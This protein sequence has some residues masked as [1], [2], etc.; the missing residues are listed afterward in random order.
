MNN[1]TAKERINRLEKYGYNPIHLF[2]SL[3]LV[4]N[5]SKRFSRFSLYSFMII[6]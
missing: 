6:K 2:G 4:R 3:Y 5:T 1:I